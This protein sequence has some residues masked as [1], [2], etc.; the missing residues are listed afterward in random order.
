MK[1]ATE[2]FWQDW[3]GRVVCDKHLGVEASSK[4]KARP[5]AKVIHTS[6]TGWLLMTEN[7]VTEFA[8][9]I[10]THTICETCRRSA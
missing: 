7:E 10:E 4:L 3:N 8:D 2:T 9:L 5:N 6:M 1:T